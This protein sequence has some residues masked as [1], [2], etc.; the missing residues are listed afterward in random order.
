MTGLI[1]QPDP[2]FGM[3]YRWCHFYPFR[4]VASGNE[5][6][7]AELIVRNHLFLPGKLEVRLKLP[8][9][10]ACLERDRTF[11]M[12]PKSQVAVPFLLHRTG[13]S[14]RRVAMADVTFNGR[15]LGEIAEFLID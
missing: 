9:D 14:G 10:V 13:G 7:R 2:N 5:P 8:D 1:L 3:D 4:V 12:E 6:F 11:T 15:R